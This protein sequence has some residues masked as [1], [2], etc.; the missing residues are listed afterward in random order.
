MTASR[1]PA[2]D[3]SALGVACLIN[4]QTEIANIRRQMELR[5]ELSAEMALALRTSLIT[6][7]GYAQQLAQNRDPEL[8]SAT[9]RRHRGRGQASGS[10]HWRISGRKQE[11]SSR[12]SAAHS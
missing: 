1:V 3:G 4:D 2:A 10:H 11:G 9:G 7:S 6:I 12:V 8:A 5:G